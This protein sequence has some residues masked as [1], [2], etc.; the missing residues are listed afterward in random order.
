VSGDV[1]LLAVYDPKGGYVTGAG[2]IESPAGAYAQNPDAIGKAHFGFFSKY[3]KGANVPSGRTDFQ[4]QAADLTFISN[5]YEWLVVAGARAQCK[6]LGT[7]NGQANFGFI[8]TAIDGAVNGGGGVDKY[9]I[10]IW[11]RSSGTIVY[12]NQMGTADTD[13]PTTVIGGGSI[14]VHAVK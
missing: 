3:E 8:V 9:R 12:D 13:N 2:W 10:K 7:L 1:I 4:F 11:N 6:G 14:I 5:Q